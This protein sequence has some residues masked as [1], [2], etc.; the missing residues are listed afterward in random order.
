[1]TVT[2]GDITLS[3]SIVLDGLENSPVIAQ[4]ARRTLGGRMVLQ[5]GATLSGGRI[6]TLSGDNHWTLGQASAIRDIAALGQNVSL[7]HHRGTFTVLI[8]QINLKLTLF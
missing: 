1:M 3:D 2:L 7:V 6:L 8:V 4:S 5:V